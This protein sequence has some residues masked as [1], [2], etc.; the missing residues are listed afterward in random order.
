MNEI[1]KYLT[2]FISNLP[3]QATEK[4]SKI[5]LPSH[6]KI[7]AS[8]PYLQIIQKDIFIANKM[9]SKRNS[10]VKNTNQEK[11]LHKG[12]KYTQIPPK[13][14]SI[15][16]SQPFF[17]KTFEFS[18]SEKESNLPSQATANLS[19]LSQAT[20]KPYNLHSPKPSN[21]STLRFDKLIFDSGDASAK[22]VNLPSQA[23][24]K[25]SNI[26][27]YLHYFLSP[28][29]P[30]MEQLD[31][32]KIN[33]YFQKCMQKI[34]IWFFL[35]NKYKLSICSKDLSIYLYL[36]NTPKLS[37]SVSSEKI[38]IDHANSGFTYGCLPKNTPN[39]IYIYREEEWF[40]VLIHET[41]HSFGMEFSSHPNIE[42][43]AN[44]KMIELFHLPAESKENYYGGGGY[45]IF[46]SY[47]EMTAEIMNILI[48]HFLYGGN[49][50]RLFEIEQKFSCFQCA[51]MILSEASSNSFKKIKKDSFMLDTYQER[52]NIFSYFILKSILLFHIN[53]YMDWAMKYNEGSLNFQ[54]TMETIQS[55]CEMIRENRNSM[56][57]LKTIGK[58]EEWLERNKEKDSLEN[59]T[60]RMTVLEF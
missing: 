42:D 56:N 22:N 49:L 15:I 1:S 3:S 41:I 28:D 54:K 44:K 59:R 34:F 57:Y 10:F 47:T 50:S 19:S 46:E 13:M 32:T 29:D 39:E 23:T 25:S 5:C 58:M 51:K 35:A 12:T 21:F 9:F 16:E 24:E 14:R 7:N 2:N 4:P 30:S 17:N 26:K 31:P 40:K 55:Y 18:F 33:I 6:E 53:S 37:P 60:L 45:N 52:T 38:D 11:Q 36:T 27:I 48:Y 20:E 43:Y 8:H